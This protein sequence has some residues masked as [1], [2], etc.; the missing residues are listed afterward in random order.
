MGKSFVNKLAMIMYKQFNKCIIRT[1]RLPF[2]NIAKIGV[3]ASLLHKKV[4]QEALYLASNNLFLEFLKFV[5][6]QL[7]SKK[8]NK[9][10]NS[11]YK[12]IVRMCSRSTPFG[13]FAGITLGNIGKETSVVLGDEIIRKTRLDMGLMFK[14]YKLLMSDANVNKNVRYKIN[15]SAYV[16]GHKLRYIECKNEMS[17]KHIMNEVVLDNVLRKIMK[18]ATSYHPFD[19]YVKCLSQLGYVREEIEIY[20]Y[21]LINEQILVGELFP[22][23][24]GGDYLEYLL[25]KLEEI[26]YKG[27]VFTLLLDV[28]KE[29]RS[30][31]EEYSDVNSHY[32]KINSLLKGINLNLTDDIFQVDYARKAKFAT[33]SNNIVDQIK[34][35]IPLLNLLSES[36]EQ[37]RMKAFK[38]AFIKRYNTRKIPIE[39]ALDEE[40]GI[41][42]NMSSEPLNMLNLLLN[43]IEFPKKNTKCGSHYSKLH[44]LLLNKLVKLSDTGENEIELLASDFQQVKDADKSD[45]PDTVYALI[46]ILD[47]RKTPLIRLKTICGSSAAIP[48]ARFSHIDPEI[49]LFIH[50]ILEKE[51]NIEVINA[52]ICH[53]PQSRMGNV[54]LRPNLRP[55][56]IP[57]LTNS[58]LEEDRVISLEDIMVYVDGGNIKL[59]SK[60]LKRV[61]S[62]FLT[63]AHN[64]NAQYNLPLYQFL[65]D[66]QTQC[67]KNDLYFSWG[68]LEQELEHLPRVRYKNIVLSLEQ[69]NMESINFQYLCRVKEEKLLEE[70]EEWRMLFNIPQEILLSEYDNELYVDFH[71]MSSVRAFLEQI[72]NKDR[73]VLL[74]F[75]Y[76]KNH[77]VVQ[78][79]ENGKYLNECI[80]FFYKV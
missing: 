1:P 21:T 44:K 71:N 35:V 46:S 61:I 26:N 66:L 25:A 43:E 37:A 62:P 72:K 2:N 70:I 65:C 77:L 23:T 55:F 20:L 4:I 11:I 30:L 50:N 5:N 69:W 15:S 14:I 53:I 52:E 67:K 17:L 51:C 63:C 33:I 36:S 31:D 78:D 75:P 79:I 76:D 56:E 58:I 80:L 27:S 24:T 73:I 68:N 3:D 13:L 9:I 8:I 7:P 28:R 48:I 12:Y 19:Y 10:Q 41:G 54:L 59:Y 74:E 6:N 29:L 38:D 32:Q 39:E 57:Y 40:Y 49:E 60:K 22:Y 34:E 18:I 45:L 16:L 64:Y 47:N 42:Y